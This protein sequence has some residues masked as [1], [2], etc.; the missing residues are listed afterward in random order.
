MKTSDL[1]KFC[2]QN[3]RMR[4]FR[5][6][7]TVVGVVIGTAAIISMISLGIGINKSSSD[8]I[9]SWG[10][11]TIINL[12]NWASKDNPTVM[13]DK[14]LAQIAAM[15]EVV[16]VSPFMYT[17]NIND[18]KIKAGK[19][20]RYE[21]YIWDIVGV[22]PNSI[23]EFGYKFGEG[24]YPEQKSSKKIFMVF[25][26]DVPYQFRDTKRSD[27]D[28]MIIPMPD[29]KTGEI[30]P[31]FFDPLGEKYTLSLEYY[32][33]GSGSDSDKKKSLDYDVAVTGVLKPDDMSYYETRNQIYFDVADLKKILEEYNKAQK[34]KTDFSKGYEN[35]KVKV[36]DI[37]NVA[38]VEAAIKEMGID[39]YS[40]EGQRQ[41]MLKETQKL[42]IILGG[43]GGVSLLVAAISIANTMVMSVYER[44]REIGIMKVLGCFVEDIRKMFLIEAAIIGFVGGV[45]GVII[46]YVISFIIN[47][48]G[49][50]SMGG[51]M[52]MMGMGMFGM[53]GESS[54]SVIPPWLVLVGMVFATT[55]GVLAGVYPAARAVKISALEAIRQD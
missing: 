4:K 36:N 21:T 13:D 48:L 54:I 53:G 44:T 34:V 33:S 55:V 9:A 38:T 18:G 11:L 16:A 20:N 31:P 46:S 45:I 12:N 52:G 3:L 41:D 47:T 5:T 28:N 49:S 15:P 22:Y 50:S 1:I 7:L 29:E 10:D 17:Y 39:T 19:S 42:Q 8:M 27:R 51:G 43:L 2:I 24:S 14:A 6:M 30:P 26:S 25:G 32:S 35:A 40:L 37:K 23:E